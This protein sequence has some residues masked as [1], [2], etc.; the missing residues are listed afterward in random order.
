MTRDASH[1]SRLKNEAGPTGVEEPINPLDRAEALVRAR[2]LRS[3]EQI[4][5]MLRPSPWYI[6]LSC[7]NSLGL[8]IAASLL[9]HY[10]QSWTDQL[11]LDQ[12]NLITL[13]AMVITLRLTWQ[14]FEWLSRIYVLTDQ[15]IIRIK[16]VLRTTIFQASLDEVSPPRLM[17]SLLERLTGIG[18]IGL[19]HQ[20]SRYFEAYWQMIATPEDVHE[21]IRETMRRYEKQHPRLES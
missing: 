4:I 9:L 18:T 15:R 17:R 6:I 10:V 12:R 3:G 1:D 19:A 2:L 13:T 16:G 5:L 11:L 7:L 8:I 21:I 20:D 14:L